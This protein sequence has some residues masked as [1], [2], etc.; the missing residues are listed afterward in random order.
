M[1]T[2]PVLTVHLDVTVRE[3][4]NNR[5]MGDDDGPVRGREDHPLR[6][7]GDRQPVAQS[8]CSSLQ[9]GKGVWRAR[10]TIDV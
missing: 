9:R 4:H 7:R 10:R 1:C 2:N 5:S 8:R 6:Y 3:A